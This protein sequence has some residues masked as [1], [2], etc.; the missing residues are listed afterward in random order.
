MPLHKDLTGADI[1][2][3]KGI[4]SAAA[5]RVYVADG[6]G[7]G[8]WTALVIPS[9]TF[10]VTTTTFT[11]SGTWTRPAKLFLARVTVVGGGGGSSFSSGTANNGGSSSFGSLVVATGGNGSNAGV[12][13]GA[14]GAGSTGNVLYSGQTGTVIASSFG[15]GGVPGLTLGNK[16]FGGS[17]M[18]GAITGVGG[19]GGAAMSWIPLIS[20]ASTVTVTVGGGG[21]GAGGGPAGSNG[22]VQVEEFVSV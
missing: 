14:A 8:A 4:A 7:S 2:E 17:A 13:I 22:I 21:A 12:P 19:G 5:G 10:I 20:L 1:H 15:I 3:P 11:S 6:A 18:S 9:G 16:G